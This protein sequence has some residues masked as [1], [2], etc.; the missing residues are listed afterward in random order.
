LTALLERAEMLAQL[1][2]DLAVGIK[3]SD[4]GLGRGRD[5]EDVIRRVHDEHARR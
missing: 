3:Q 5:V 2:A 1:G 4:A